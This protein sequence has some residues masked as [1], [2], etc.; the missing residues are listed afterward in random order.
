MVPSQDPHVV[1][2]FHDNV[3]GI[4]VITSLLHWPSVVLKVDLVSVILAIQSLHVSVRPGK[5]V[6]VLY[7]Q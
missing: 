4:H 6:M 2:D 3:V 1:T 7:K 5:Y